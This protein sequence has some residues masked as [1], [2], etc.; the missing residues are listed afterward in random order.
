VRLSRMRILARNSRHSGEL[1]ARVRL[2]HVRVTER[3]RPVDEVDGVGGSTSVDV[4]DAS[5]SIGE[6]QKASSTL[7][8]HQDNRLP[9]PQLIVPSMPRYRLQGNDLS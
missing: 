6:D 1:T 4:A 5:A 3:C 2:P 7:G 9:T 8:A